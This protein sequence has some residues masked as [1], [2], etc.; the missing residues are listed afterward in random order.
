MFPAGQLDRMRD[1]GAEI[2]M[3]LDVR[4]EHTGQSAEGAVVDPGAA[5]FV[6]SAKPDHPW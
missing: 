1:F 3:C 2:V 6:G 5:F 4:P